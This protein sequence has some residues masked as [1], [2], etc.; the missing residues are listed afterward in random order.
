MENPAFCL[1]RLLSRKRER[2]SL[3]AAERAQTGSF[4]DIMF[5]N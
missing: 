1:T 3:A 4:V 5:R 2:G